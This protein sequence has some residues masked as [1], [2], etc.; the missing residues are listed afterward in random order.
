MKTYHG[1]RTDRGCEVTVDGRP[2]GLRSDL[3]GNA[4]TAFDW[5]YVGSG[6]LSL[7]LLSDFLGDDR[8]AERL[9]AGFEESVIAHLPQGSWTLTGPDLTAAI[10]PL[11]VVDSDRN[12]ARIRREETD[13][14]LESC[15]QCNGLGMVTPVH[16]TE[17][18]QGKVFTRSG[19]MRWSE[20]C[21]KCG[22]NGKVLTH[23]GKAVAAVVQHVQECG[24]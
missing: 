17:D 20:T 7:A 9:A 3:S 1:E 15:D 21:R 12:R 24:R 8:R 5:G 23:A 16:S 14:L 10:E 13:E 6:Q 4:T 19:I 22:G 18:T 11:T 2:L